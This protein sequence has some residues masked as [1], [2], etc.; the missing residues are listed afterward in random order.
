MSKVNFPLNG[1]LLEQVC[2]GEIYLGGLAMGALSL[3]Y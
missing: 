1:E 2:T 3:F